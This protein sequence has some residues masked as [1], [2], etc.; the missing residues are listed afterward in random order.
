[1]LS[2]GAG[3]TGVEPELALVKHKQLVGGGSLQLVNRTVVR[4]LEGLGYQP[5]EITEA[6]ALVDA[7]L[8]VEEQLRDALRTLG[9]GRLR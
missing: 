7:G 1:M 2:T 4:A 6:L 5:A 9:K 3:L 8:G